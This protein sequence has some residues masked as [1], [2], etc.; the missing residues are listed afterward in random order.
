MAGSSSIRSQVK[1]HHPRKAVPVMMMLTPLC[2][3]TCYYLF[4]FFYI[5]FFYNHNFCFLYI[6]ILLSQPALVATESTWSLYTFYCYLLE[7]QSHNET[8]PSCPNSKLLDNGTHG[9]SLVQ[10]TCSSTFNSG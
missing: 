6:C 9:P 4:V 10:V 2:S 1:N 7:F 3:V 8:D 5:F